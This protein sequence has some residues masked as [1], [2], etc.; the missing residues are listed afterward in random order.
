MSSTLPKIIRPFPKAALKVKKTKRVLVKST[1][2]TD[3][4]KKL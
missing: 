1:V 4:P 3:T 2:Y